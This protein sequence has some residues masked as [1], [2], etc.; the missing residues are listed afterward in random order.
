M[1]VI[2]DE[3]F[4]SSENVYN[5]CS[6]TNYSYCGIAHFVLPDILARVL[7]TGSESGTLPVAYV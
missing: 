2:Y 1:T 5:E 6:Y 3:M 7:N 4:E